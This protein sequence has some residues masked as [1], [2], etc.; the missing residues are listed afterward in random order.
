MNIKEIVLAGAMLLSSAVFSQ[1]PDKLYF[2]VYTKWDGLPK[3]NSSS[4]NVIPG[5]IDCSFFFG[6][7]SMKFKKVN[8][9]TYHETVKTGIFW[10]SRE[11]LFEYSFKDSSYI[12]EKYSA[13]LGKSR[14]EKSVL[15]ETIYNKKYKDLL[16]LIDDFE[17]GLFGDSLHLIVQGIPYS[18]KIEKTQKGKDI[19]YFSNPPEIKDEPGD[20]MTF[21]FPFQLHAKEENEKIIP[22]E[23]HT[24]LLN[25]KSGKKTHLE[26]I[27]NE[28]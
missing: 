3:I 22:I 25:V 9:S 23:F 24:K 8:D 19:L 26:G 28:D 10:S 7:Y 12:L 14:E 2:D 1:S 15:E 21:S 18:V 27:L 5:E 6:L 17:N 13:I 16:W 20:F 4:V 11:E